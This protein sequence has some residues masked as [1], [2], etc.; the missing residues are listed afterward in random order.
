MKCR[1][2]ERPLVPK[3]PG[4]AYKSRLVTG[5]TF[6]SKCCAE[7]VTAR[8]KPTT[9]DVVDVKYVHPQSGWW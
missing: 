1:K 7:E 3:G 5:E 8:Q 9:T 2:C 4:E 6:C